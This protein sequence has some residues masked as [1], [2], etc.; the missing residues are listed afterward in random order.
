MVY[1]NP[2]GPRRFVPPI[3]VALVLADTNQA[4]VIGLAQERANIDRVG[5]RAASLDR[6]LLS[7][8]PMV[9]LDD[10]ELREQGYGF[11]IR[12]WRAC[13]NSPTPPVPS[14]DER[15]PVP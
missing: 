9:T 11:A 8:E 7:V 10:L 6:V 3:P 5:P 4:S 14:S 12:V 13:H 2:D 15:S 1:P